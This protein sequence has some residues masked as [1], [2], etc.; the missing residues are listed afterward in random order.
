[1]TSPEGV[2]FGGDG[3]RKG[4]ARRQVDIEGYQTERHGR[5]KEEEQGSL[6]GRG[7]GVISSELSGL[8]K[9]KGANHWGPTG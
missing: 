4:A 2:T 8:R 6:K 3:R 5:S 1:V 9:T 7:R